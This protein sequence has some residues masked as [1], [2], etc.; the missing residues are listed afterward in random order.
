MTSAAIAVA[1]AIAGGIGAAGRFVLDGVITSRSRASVPIATLVINV[2]G[3]FLLGLVAG[4]AAE[5]GASSVTALLGIGLL[6]GFTTFSTA[7][8]ELVALVRDDRHRAA[9]V[10]AVGMLLLALAAAVLGFG[11]AR[12]LLT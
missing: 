2:V 12:S 1:I 6:G 5:R 10:L 11:L 9:V 3:S 7:S 8:V 4:W